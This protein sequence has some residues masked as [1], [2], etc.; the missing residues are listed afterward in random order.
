[1]TDLKRDFP[2][3]ST[4]HKGPSGNSDL[5]VVQDDL[6]KSV[7]S[8]DKTQTGAKASLVDQLHDIQQQKQQYFNVDKDYPFIKRTDLYRELQT[9]CTKTYLMHSICSHYNERTFSPEKTGM[10]RPNTVLA[11]FAVKAEMEEDM[12]LDEFEQEMQEV[13][14]HL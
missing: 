9:L 10:L 4:S 8:H 11:G 1:M 7:S 2:T 12:N 3:R 5:N 6:K 14:R 13:P